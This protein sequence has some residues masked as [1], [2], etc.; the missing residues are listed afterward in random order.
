[1]LCAMATKIDLSDRESLVNSATTSLASKVIS[2]NSALLAPMAVD[3]VLK[4]IDPKTACN[5]DLKDIRVLKKVTSSSLSLGLFSMEKNR[6]EEP[7][8]TL[9]LWME[10]CSPKDV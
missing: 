2:Q 9:L 7:L 5:V 6:L 1:M 8:M 10:L 3:A 4:V